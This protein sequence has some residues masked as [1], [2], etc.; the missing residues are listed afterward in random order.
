MPFLRMCARALRPAGAL[1]LALALSLAG[2][3]A[4]AQPA[5]P[6]LPE[7]REGMPDYRPEAGGAQDVEASR[8]TP[9]E[10]PGDSARGAWR[11]LSRE[12][13]QAIRRLSQEER[14]ALAGRSGHPGM[15]APPAPPPGAVPPGGRLSPQ[16]RRE[17]RRQIRE[18]HERRGLHLGSGKRP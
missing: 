4:L 14:E 17:L 18:D 11:N 13:R 9:R 3:C 16:E 5:G 15:I 10:M 6:G 8:F 7:R 12:Q 2:R 1:S